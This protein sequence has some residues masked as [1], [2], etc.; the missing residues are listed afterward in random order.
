MSLNYKLLIIK[1]LFQTIF[2]K[3]VV[4]ILRPKSMYKR[5][6]MTDRL[7]YEWI[8]SINKICYLVES[9]VWSKVSF[10]Q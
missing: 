9:Y 8:F 4:S 2:T 3:N 5:K 1:S 7:Y 6:R 10:F